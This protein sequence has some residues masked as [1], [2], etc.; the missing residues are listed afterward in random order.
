MR[1]LAGT[2]IGACGEAGM[3]SLLVFDGIKGRMGN[4][5]P[6]LPFNLFVELGVVGEYDT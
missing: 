1:V 5:E 4:S 6:I 3:F 2:D